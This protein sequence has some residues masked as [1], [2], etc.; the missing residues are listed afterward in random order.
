MVTAA[1]SY[2]L[3]SNNLTRSLNQVA[4][5]PA[6]K[7]QTDYYLANIGKVKSIDDFMANS[8]IYQYAMKAFGLQDMA[9]AKAFMRK[10]LEGGVAASD[11]FANT[12]T[13]KRYLDFATA[14]N[15]KQYNTAT[16]SFDRTQQGTVDK[17]NQQ[18]LEESA[19]ASDEGVRLALYFSRAAPNVDTVLGLLADPALLKVTQTVLGLPAATGALNIDKQVALISKR[20]NIADLKDPAK[21]K[22]LITRFTAMWEVQK[23]P[24]AATSSATILLGGSTATGISSD[25]LASIQN[26]RLGGN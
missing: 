12:L 5:T 10:V 6:A 18:L 2:Q 21:L 13:D 16:T 9:Y 3:I 7:R 15:F 22:K 14:F 8:Q 1:V 24:T 23:D 17:Y 26:L 4:S 20:L 25:L 11:S 19:G